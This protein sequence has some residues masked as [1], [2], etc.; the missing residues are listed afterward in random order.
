MKKGEG[1]TLSS[2]GRP[3]EGVREREV[4]RHFV[5]EGDGAFSRKDLLR[6]GGTTT[7]VFWPGRSTRLEKDVH[8]ANNRGRT[9]LSLRRSGETVDVW[10]LTEGKKIFRW[11]WGRR[12]PCKC[13]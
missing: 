4:E 6:K 11:G 7:A 9:K 2:K 10:S 5:L 3:H 1:P 12:I 8:D 13:V